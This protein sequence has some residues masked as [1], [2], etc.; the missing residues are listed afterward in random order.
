MDAVSRKKTVYQ[1]IKLVFGCISFGMNPLIIPQMPVF[2][3]AQNRVRISNINNQKHDLPLYFCVQVS[4]TRFKDSK[5]KNSELTCSRVQRFSVQRFIIEHQTYQEASY[6][7]SPPGC[8][9]P[10]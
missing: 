5:F 6:D 1:N 8:S 3:N 10:G 4:V 2:I 9:E 7:Y